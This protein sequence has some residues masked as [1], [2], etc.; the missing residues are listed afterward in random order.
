MAMATPMERTAR[1][2]LARKI[3]FVREENSFTRARS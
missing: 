3:R 1:A 2:E